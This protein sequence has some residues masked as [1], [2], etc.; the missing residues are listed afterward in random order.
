MRFRRDQNV[1]LPAASSARPAN[2]N[3]VGGSSRSTGGGVL[4]KRNDGGQI[5]IAHMREH[6]A[7]HRDERRD[8]PGG[9]RDESRV[10][11]RDQE[12]FEP[13]PPLPRVRFDPT[14]TPSAPMSAYTRPPTSV[15][16]TH[17]A[18]ADRL[19]DVLAAGDVLWRCGNHDRNRLDV[20]HLVQRPLADRIDGCDDDAGEHDDHDCGPPNEA[21]E[22]CA[23]S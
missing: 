6:F 10:N 12:N 8:R 20:V 21:R 18:G 13:T 4:E 1:E 5:A 17:R 19:R 3:R 7:R 14:M 15:S 16:V 22:A 2:P 23:E 9:H 11:H